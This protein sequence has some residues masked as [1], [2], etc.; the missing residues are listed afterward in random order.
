MMDVQSIRAQIERARSKLARA[1][2]EAS[3]TSEHLER[4][5]KRLR[6]ILGCESGDERSALQALRDKVSKSRQEVMDLLEQAERAAE[7]GEG[8]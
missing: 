3:A 7:G 2:G 6:E 5:M 4:S 1:Q 8:A